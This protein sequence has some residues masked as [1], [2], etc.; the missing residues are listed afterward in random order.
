MDYGRLPRPD[1]PWPEA[2]VKRRERWTRAGK[3]W[4][5]WPQKNGDALE[6][7]RN[8][9][10][11]T[12]TG[13]VPTWMKSRRRNRGPAQWLLSTSD[14][15]GL[16]L[17][18]SLCSGQIARI[19]AERLNERGRARSRFWLV[20]PC[21]GGCGVAGTTA[22]EMFSRSM[23]SYLLHPMVGPALLWNTAAKRRIMITCVSSCALWI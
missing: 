23:V 12:A 6:A 14:R 9:L 8:A 5:N 10:H 18:T 2:N 22:E 19:I 1:Q 21:I 20:A 7:L 11:L 16:I 17:P 15:V 4:R 3:I 13:C